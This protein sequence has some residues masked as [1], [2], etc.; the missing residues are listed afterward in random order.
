MERR[1]PKSMSQPVGKSQVRCVTLCVQN[2]VKPFG[3]LSMVWQGLCCCVGPGQRQVSAGAQNCGTR[4]CVRLQ[5]VWVFPWRSSSPFLKETVCGIPLSLP[6]AEAGGLLGPLI[7]ADVQWEFERCTIQDLPLWSYL[8][9][10][11]VQILTDIFLSHT[12]LQICKVI[13]VF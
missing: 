5:I 7:P 1:A 6:L 2:N 8:W 3:Q 12:A 10:F 11:P 9:G 4:F 13:A